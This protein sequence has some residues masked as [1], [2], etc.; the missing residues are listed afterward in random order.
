MNIRLVSVQDGQQFENIKTE[1]LI[2]LVTR[3]LSLAS[4]EGEE[5]TLDGNIE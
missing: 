1:F 2:S 4:D 5:R 3:L